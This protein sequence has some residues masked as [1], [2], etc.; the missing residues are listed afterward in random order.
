[1]FMDF[2]TPAYLK[3][4]AFWILIISLLASFVVSENFPPQ[5]SSHKKLAVIEK[6]EKGDYYY[7][8]GSEKTSIKLEE[9]ISLDESKLS[10]QSLSNLND[11][12][13]ND[14][15]ANTV[16]SLPAT[17]LV[18]KLELVAGGLKKKV[19]YELT[20]KKHYGFYSLLP[21]FIAIL[22]CWITH[23][24][25]ISLFLATVSGAIMLGR[26][27]YLN[28]V[29]VPSFGSEGAVGIVIL[30]LWLLG[31]LMGIWSRTGA[32]RAFAEWATLHF[33]SGPRSARLVAWVLGMIFFQGGTV[34]S[35]L[36]GTTVRPV[37]D[38]QKVSHEELSYIVDSTSSPIACLLAFNAW[39]AYIQAFLFVPGVVFLASES[40]RLSFF[41]SSLPLSF[42]S[43]LAVIGTFLFCI[44]KQPFI[45]KR[46]KQ[47]KLRARNKGELDATN[48]RS[49]NAKE[50]E[51]PV[52]PKGYKPHYLEFI[53]PLII[54]LGVA[55]GT[56]IS[57][58]KPQVSLAFGLALGFAIFSAL[59]RGMSLQ[60]LVSGLGDGF[61]GVVLGALILLFAIT[62]GGIT[63]EVGGGIYLKELF[64]TSIPYF[65]LPALL[66]I[67]T[68][69][70]S[71]STGTSWGTYAIVYPLAMPLAW[72]VGAELSHPMLF[73]SL[74]FAVVLNSSVIGD[75]SS[76][77]SDTTI[78]SS[79]CTGCD[80]MEHV[81]TQLIPVAWLSLFSIILWT[82]VSFFCL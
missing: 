15:R 59:A 76:P 60:D 82:I 23:E 41:F 50:I 26:F 67:L 30:Y 65:I 44:D 38:K 8:K 56:F 55:V 16:A 10:Q 20:L 53:L 14:S 12:L 70:I 4:P 78:L 2:K 69:V 49:M 35:V 7:K 68:I 5:Y 54:L 62:I 29:I 57:G 79:M 72:V 36:V 37:A 13:D 46:M 22:F 24:A 63:K 45:G 27:D 43:I 3:K 73:M 48:A 71:F 75:Q 61:K 28:D 77:I 47:A 21:A 19:Y 31:G 52:I 9:I 33:V 40:D 80:L 25:L 81:R 42:Y 6:N 74:C 17:E 34:S 32:A 51:N 39:P 64:G 1:M 66:S 18:Y 58:G 11:N